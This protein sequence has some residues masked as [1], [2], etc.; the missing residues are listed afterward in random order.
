MDPEYA[1]ASP[2]NLPYNPFQVAQHGLQELGNIAYQVVP[3]PVI[4]AGRSMMR[5][6]PYSGEKASLDSYKQE[7]QLS[8]APSQV[9]DPAY[10]KTPMGTIYDN[11]QQADAAMQDTMNMVMGIMGGAGGPPR[12]AGFSDVGKGF[13]YGGKIHDTGAFHDLTKLPEHLQDMPV[14]LEDGWILRG[15][16]APAQPGTSPEF[17]R[18]V[19]REDWG[20]PGPGMLGR[21]E[22]PTG[23][24]NEPQNPFINWRPSEGPPPISMDQSALPPP[25]E[26]TNL[27]KNSPGG[28]S[29][30]QIKA[31]ADE[32][33]RN[34]AE[35]EAFM[36]KFNKPNDQPFGAGWKQPPGSLP[37]EAPTPVAPGQDPLTALLARYRMED[38]IR[39]PE[40]QSLKK[41]PRA[42]ASNN[43]MRPEK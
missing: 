7:Q 13:M 24:A 41:A 6:T 11:R 42:A 35:T 18:F 12:G 27:F 10:A 37:G 21:P 40:L 25:V 36:A 22:F 2:G 26:P 19:R 8:G 3:D 30:Q 1:T 29:P 39:S 38:L 32:V 34:K 31:A 4:A 23:A 9:Q 17:P 33:A 16:G 5:G 28:L 14:G 43:P 15:E 20:K